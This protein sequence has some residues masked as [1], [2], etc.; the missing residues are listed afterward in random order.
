MAPIVL[1]EAEEADEEDV[2][3]IREMCECPVIFCFILA[4]VFY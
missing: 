2:G 3:D 4:L 1:S